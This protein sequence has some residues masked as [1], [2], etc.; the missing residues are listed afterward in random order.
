MI[1]ASA[2][3][4]MASEN[5]LLQAISVMIY[6]GSYLLMKRIRYWQ[7]KELIDSFQAEPKWYAKTQFVILGLAVG[8]I[9]GVLVGKF[10]LDV[11]IFIIACYGVLTVRY[12][13]G[14]LFLAHNR[15]ELAR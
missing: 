9:L 2:I 15:Y 3:M 1:V 5:I 4:L 7:L 10:G 8:V 11:P 12:F 13:L 6:V 14:E